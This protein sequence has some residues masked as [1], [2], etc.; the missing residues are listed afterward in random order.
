M[1]RHRIVTIERLGG[2][3]ARCEVETD[4]KVQLCGITFGGFH[5]LT[6]ARSA[7]QHDYEGAN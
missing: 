2:Y 3:A 5:T 7:L 1:A 4:G 6:E